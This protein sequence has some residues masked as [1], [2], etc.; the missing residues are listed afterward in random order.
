MNNLAP[1]LTLIS[2]AETYFMPKVTK[3]EDSG[4]WIWGGAKTADG[5]GLFFNGEQTERAHRFSYR[6]YVAEIPQG[7]LLL[8]R[9]DNPS[10]VNP[11][12]LVVGTQL[13][14]VADMRRKNRAVDVAGSKHGRAKLSEE[15]VVSIRADGRCHA[16]IAAE[17]GVSKGLISQIKTRTIWAH[18]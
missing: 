9:C 13:E 6:A 4:C 17:H 16:V 7:R 18:I 3:D 2:R 11:Q 12:H 8:H 1:S 14:N 5:Y 15:K 10:C